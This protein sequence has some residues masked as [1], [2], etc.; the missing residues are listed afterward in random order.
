MGGVGAG[1][2]GG[3]GGGGGGGEPRGVASHRQMTVIT[4]HLHQGNKLEDERAN[5]EHGRECCFQRECIM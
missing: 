4:D 2:G 3:A 5:E 1:R